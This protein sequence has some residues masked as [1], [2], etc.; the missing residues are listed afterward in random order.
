M[1]DI[2]TILASVPVGAVFRRHERGGGIQVQV[3]KN[4][5]RHRSSVVEHTLGKG[6]VTGSSPVGGLDTDLYVAD[7]PWQCLALRGDE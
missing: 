5:L 2:G 3:G 1:A 6:E 4:D 7:G